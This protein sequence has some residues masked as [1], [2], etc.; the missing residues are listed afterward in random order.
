MNSRIAGGPST[1]QNRGFAALRFTAGRRRLSA[2]VAFALLVFTP[3]V[4]AAVVLQYHHISDRTPA[5]TSTSPERFA[6]HLEYLAEHGFDVVPLQDLVDAL[7]RGEALPDRTAA[8]TFDDGYLSIFEVAWP[9]LRARG[10]PFTVFVSTGPHDSGQRP[11]LS[12]DQIRELQAGGATIANHTVSHAYLVRRQPS[13]GEAAWRDWAT[14]EIVS[15]ERR[16]AAETGQTVKLLA[17]PYGEYDAALREIAASL[18]YAAFGQHS[19]PLAAHSDPV[20][21][22]RFPFGGPYGDRQD[23]ATKVNSLPLPLAAGRASI[24]LFGKDRLPLDDSVLSRDRTPPL[25][26]LRLEASFDP[27][28]L[29]CFATGQGPARVT[30]ESPWI[31][32]QAL[33]PL[34]PGRSRYNCTAPAGPPGRYYWYSQPW[35]IQ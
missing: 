21:L 14:A 22:P 11:F 20:A 26:G 13:G 27:Q 19:G 10:W 9:M 1:R 30:V 17:W 31:L 35:L 33:A 29:S 25:L 18:G 24:R 5:S 2:W 28:R 16:I 23:F 12:W 32:V 8:I 34:D 6:M 15:A 7:G 3:A 4:S